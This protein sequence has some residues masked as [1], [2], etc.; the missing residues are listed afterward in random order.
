M[1]EIP[2][3]HLERSLQPLHRLLLFG[4]E[5]VGARDIVGHVGGKAGAQLQ[6]FLVGGNRV[7]IVLLLIQRV[8]ELNREN[9]VDGIGLNDF[10]PERGSIRPSARRCRGFGFRKRFS[11]TVDRAL[12][13][14]DRRAGATQE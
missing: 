11:K 3:A 8:C 1:L 2:K 9:S 4:E 10:L 13:E 5:C 6:R 7:A 12:G 14:C